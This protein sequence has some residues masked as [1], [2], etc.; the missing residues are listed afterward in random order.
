MNVQTYRADTMPEALDLVRRELGGDAIVLS[1]RQV[2][3]KR[4]FPW[5]RMR[6]EA[7]VVAG[8]AE[9]TAP[10]RS[11]AERLTLEP[12]EDSLASEPVS[13]NDVNARPIAAPDPNDQQ[14]S[15]PP[16]CIEHEDNASGNNSEERPL[17][18][19]STSR[20]EAIESLVAQLSSRAS[21]DRRIEVPDNLF[22]IFASLI[23]SDIAE[24]DARRLIFDLNASADGKTVDTHT[25]AAQ[26]AELVES[27]I[28]CNGGISLTPGLRHV[29]ALVGPTGVGKTTS[30]AKLA[31]NFK[32][33][34]GLQVGLV[35][36]DTYRVAAVEQLRTYAEIIDLPMHVVTTAREMRQSLDELSDLDLVLIDTAGRSPRDELKIHELKSLLA[37]AGVDDVL[38]VLSAASSLRSLERAAERFSTVAPT[39]VLLTKLDEVG[40][41]GS[42]FSAARCVGLP[43]SYF[44]TGQDVPDDIEAASSRR[45]ARLILG[46]EDLFRQKPVT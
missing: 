40:G 32:L 46:E 10:L 20:T 11:S 21:R 34:D 24:D 27:R 22:H 28:Q 45:A 16:P 43:I 12:A 19:S 7:E 6:F 37:E 3:L 5:Q 41:L 23:D 1:T 44:T 18:T 36:V 25:A 33:R 13:S 38:L 30:I 15:A 4:R 35:T 39:A 8:I 17:S 42:V 26:L 31:A 29:V 2:Q 9:Q 14:V